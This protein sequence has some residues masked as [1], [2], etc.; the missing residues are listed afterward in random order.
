MQVYSCIVTFNKN[1]M[2]NLYGLDIP[3]KKKN[4]KMKYELPFYNSMNGR[5]ADKSAV[6]KPLL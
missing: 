1:L 2:D 5:L 3:K 6:L 4:G